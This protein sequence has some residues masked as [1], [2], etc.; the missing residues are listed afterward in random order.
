[1]NIL[2]K[3]YIDRLIDQ[4]RFVKRSIKHWLFGALVPLPLI[5]LLSED[6][7]KIFLMIVVVHC[8]LISAYLI[9]ELS[10]PGI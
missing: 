3:I 7:L 6:P 2:N 9:Y 4:D 10:R 1:M 8:I 5:L